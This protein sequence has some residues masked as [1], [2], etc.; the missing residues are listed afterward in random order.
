MD[1]RD[2][3]EDDRHTVYM[4]SRRPEQAKRA[5]VLPVE[6]ESKDATTL[7][8]VIPALVAGIQLSANFGA[9]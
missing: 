9:S 6:M 8:V 1:P 3:P 7:N 4:A 2:K 5:R